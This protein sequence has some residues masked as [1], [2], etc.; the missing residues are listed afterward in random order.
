VW[1]VQLSGGSLYV[2][3]MLSG[4]WQLSVPQ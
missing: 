3:D 4:L 1:G 2:I